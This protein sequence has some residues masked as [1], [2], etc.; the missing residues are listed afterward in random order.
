MTINSDSTHQK[1]MKFA[2]IVTCSIF[3]QSYWVS[4]NVYPVFTWP[5]LDFLLTTYLFCSTWLLND[6]LLPNFLWSL[7]LALFKRDICI[8]LLQTLLCYNLHTS[9]MAFVV[10]FFSAA[11]EFEWILILVRCN[12]DLGIL[13]LWFSGYFCSFFNFLHLVTLLMRFSDKCF[14]DQN[15][16]KSR[17]HCIR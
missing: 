2:F 4:D 9:I 8:V 6:P 7:L 16:T 14:G 13:D 11:F 1:W 12:L 15:V 5:S 3:L 17:V 10:D